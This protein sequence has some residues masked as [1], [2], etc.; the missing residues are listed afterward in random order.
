MGPDLNPFVIVTSGAP[1]NITI[2][3]DLNGDTMPRAG[4]HSRMT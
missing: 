3:R 1:F 2:G 4:L